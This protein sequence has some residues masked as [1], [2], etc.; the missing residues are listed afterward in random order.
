MNV[1]IFTRYSDLPF[2]DMGKW[3]SFVKKRKWNLLFC[4]QFFEIL[5]ELA[6]CLDNWQL[7]CTDSQKWF[8]TCVG[9]FRN[10]LL[11][12]DPIHTRQH[13]L[14]IRHTPVYIF[15][16]SEQHRLVVVDDSGRLEV[17]GGCKVALGRVVKGCICRSF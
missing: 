11:L 4:S 2:S 14:R 17:G 12:K 15:E 16:E 13:F 9:S 7:C 10:A 3:I 6:M 5:I 1:K 8:R